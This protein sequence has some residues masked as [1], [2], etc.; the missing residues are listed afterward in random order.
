MN[1]FTGTFHNEEEKKAYDFTANACMQIISLEEDKAIIFDEDKF[2]RGWDYNF[3]P[4]EFETPQGN[5]DKFLTMIRDKYNIWHHI[6]PP[7]FKIKFH[8]FRKEPRQ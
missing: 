7:G 1:R 6:E 5:M 4:E 8:R 3:N 2:R